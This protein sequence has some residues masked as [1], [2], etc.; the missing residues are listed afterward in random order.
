MEIA[1]L[2]IGVQ[3]MFLSTREYCRPYLTAKEPDFFV[4][5]TP[6]DLVY[7]Q[8]LLD[9]EALEE[10]LK[11]R[12]FKD[13]FLERA[14]IQR[15]VADYLVT[16][17]TLMLHG[18]TVAVD[19]KAY[20]FT[21]PCGTGKTTHT[22]LWRDLLGQRAVMVNDDKPFLRI[23]PTGVLAY[24]SPWS[25]K[26]GLATNICVPLQ[27]ICALRRGM[28]NRIEPA[29]AQDLLELLCHQTHIPQDQALGEKTRCLVETLAQRVPLW[30]MECT[31]DPQAAV[32]SYTAMAEI[33]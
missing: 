15:Q 6:E 10:G 26:H 17:D 31:K 32:V 22:R 8:K 25:G 23:T 30:Q 19:G 2:V 7:E 21:A 13:P 4:T 12:V 24:G 3:P 14:S 1:D 33:S 9:Q 20:L 11:F 28:D 29:Q 27:G 16:R 18:S 5:V